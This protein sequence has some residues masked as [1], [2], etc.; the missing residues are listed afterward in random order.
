MAEPP[1]TPSNKHTKSIDV[2]SPSCPQP[3]PHEGSSSTDRAYE[4]FVTTEEPHQ[5]EGVERGMIRRLVMRN[6]FETKSAGSQ[7]STSEYSSASTV[8]AKK[9]LKGRFRLSKQKDDKTDF[10]TK[11]WDG[12]DE[13]GKGKGKRPQ[14]S[15]KASGASAVSGLSNDTRSTRGSPARSDKHAEWLHTS[16]VESVDRKFVLKIDPGAHC[17]DPFDVLPVPGSR[18]LDM[19][20][21]LCE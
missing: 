8:M 4:F 12:K 18:Q 14:T 2:S 13:D 16:D 17:F 3:T 10:T 6:F 21:K 20:F 7:T 1:K 19:L 15:R 9:Q 5:P 11:R